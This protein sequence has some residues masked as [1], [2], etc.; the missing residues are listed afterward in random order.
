MHD[1]FQAA[2]ADEGGLE[3]GAGR[4]LALNAERVLHAVRI[5][6]I[7]VENREYLQPAAPLC[8]VGHDLTK[9]IVEHGPDDSESGSVLLAE[10]RSER[11][12]LRANRLPHGPRLLAAE[13]NT[14]TSA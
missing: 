14:K 10:S 6:N 1:E 2:I 12:V 13:Q 11:D 7:G 4:K 5:L 8:L 9:L 3:H